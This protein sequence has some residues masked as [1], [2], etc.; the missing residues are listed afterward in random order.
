M[1]LDKHVKALVMHVTFL[2]TIVIRLAKKAKIALLVAKE[3]KITTEYLDFSD[4]FLEKKA[5]IL[6]KVFVQYDK[7]GKHIT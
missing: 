5:S 1:A 4:V 6:P 2:S 7:Q 3:V